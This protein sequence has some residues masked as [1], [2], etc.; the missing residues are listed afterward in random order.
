MIMYEP[1]QR[2]GESAFEIVEG[3]TRAAWTEDDAVFVYTGN[4]DER[5]DGFQFAGYLHWTDGTDEENIN[6]FREFVRNYQHKWE[7]LCKRTDDPKLKFIEALLSQRN[8]PSRRNGRSFH[9]PILEVPSQ[10]LDA[11]L[12]I[13][14]EDVFGDGRDFDEIPDDDAIF[15]R[16]FMAAPDLLRALSQL[17][18]AVERFTNADAFG[19]PELDEARKALRRA[20]QAE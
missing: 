1:W 7:T 3:T 12:A 9:A 10:H 17:V 15:N 20:A 4:T 19:W 14:S 6:R 18:E 5:E 11:A 2:E 13:F 8:I 16:V